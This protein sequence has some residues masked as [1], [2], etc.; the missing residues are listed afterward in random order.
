ML[1]VVRLFQGLY[2]R[3]SEEALRRG[4]LQPNSGLNLTFINARIWKIRVYSLAHLHHPLSSVRVSH[5]E[6]AD[7]RHLTHHQEDVTL[8]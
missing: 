5:L 1:E 7:P 3:V 6:Q 8:G 2:L 4:Q